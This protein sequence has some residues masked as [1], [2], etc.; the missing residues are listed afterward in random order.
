MH[1]F[2]ETPFKLPLMQKFNFDTIGSIVIGGSACENL[3][4]IAAFLNNG[5][6]AQKKTMKMLGLPEDSPIFGLCLAVIGPFEINGNNLEAVRH[7]MEK[8]NTLLSKNSSRLVL[9]NAEYDDPELLNGVCE[10]LSNIHPCIGNGIIRTKS[11]TLL[12]IG[13]GVPLGAKWR[14]E[15]GYNS[16]EFLP[17]VNIEEI[18]SEKIQ[19][20]LMILSS[21]PP[22]FCSE[23]P[24]VNSDWVKQEPSVRKKFL[25]STFEMDK[26]YHYIVS[27]GINGVKWFANSNSEKMKSNDVTIIDKTSFEIYNPDERGLKATFKSG[28]CDVN[29]VEVRMPFYHGYDIR[30]IDVEVNGDNQVQRG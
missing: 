16:F 28:L 5:R 20:G 12:V 22:T 11:S 15:H 10:G 23:I 21:Y 26:L 3:D 4:G 14:S 27:V 1:I 17:S 25:D 18:A 2:A 30:N 7:E 24:P 9:I 6:Q 13:G 8:I 19:D 29:S